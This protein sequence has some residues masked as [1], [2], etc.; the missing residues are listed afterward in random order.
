MISEN[1]LEE[2][3]LSS[4]LLELLSQIQYNSEFKTEETEKGFFISVVALA[5]G[6]WNNVF[7]PS[8]ELKE[9]AKKLIDVP[10]KIEHGKDEKWGDEVVGRV[11]EANY[12]PILKSIVAKIKVEN[13]EIIDQIKK[14]LWKGVSVAL[15]VDYDLKDGKLVGRV[16]RFW[17]ISLTNRPACA[18]C[19]IIRSEEKMSEEVKEVEVKEEKKEELEQ[20][21]EV[22][23]EETKEELTEE[24][25]KETVE[26][27]EEPK[28]DS[29]EPEEKEAKKEYP[30]PY[31]YPV[32]KMDEVL[33]KLDDIMEAIK[34]LDE[35]IKEMSETEEDKKKEEYP[36]YPKPEEKETE[37]APV[38][39]ENKESKEE[40]AK[41]EMSK[42]DKE[43]QKKELNLEEM[44]VKEASEL[45]IKLL[46]K[47]G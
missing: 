43:E 10:L 39:E 15:T 31:P 40:P 17:E 12:D 2:L 1:V 6:Q 33:K 8:E 46:R 38:V 5:E 4:K 19:Y 25:K 34:K 3:A 36:E 23:E 14:G 42:E 32:P 24:A 11:V 26:S 41:E 7:Y 21:E 18:G 22:K 20:K 35:K 16:D 13:Q 29:K 30:Y 47:L 45:I 27:C 9:N 37:Q 28:E 44:D